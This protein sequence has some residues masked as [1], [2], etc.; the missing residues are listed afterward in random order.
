MAK[1]KAK[2]TGRFRNGRRLCAATNKKTGKPCNGFAM[3]GKDVCFHHGGNTPSGMAAPQT[4]HG[5]Y[6]SH[7][8]ARLLAKF[9]E[10]AADHELYQMRLDISLLEARE[11]ELFTRLDY[12]DSP[13][14]W[15]QLQAVSIG[16][17]SYLYGSNSTDEDAPER[18]YQLMQE[19]QTLTRAGVEEWR[20]WEEI[21]R[22][23]DAK[24]KTID[25]ERKH[26]L[27]MEQ[28]FA[29]QDVVG[30]IN[31]ILIVGKESIKSQND[32]TSFVNGVYQIIEEEEQSHGQNGTSP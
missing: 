16:L 17:H 3:K 26:M 31:R 29:F 28:L 20:T 4:K 12:G 5:R 13:E 15:K 23:V 10:A 14:L 22:V 25:G 8:P 21:N 11:L 9:Q 2:H 6:S 7:L 24:R 30:I 27:Q 32:L 19:L 1:S 18:M